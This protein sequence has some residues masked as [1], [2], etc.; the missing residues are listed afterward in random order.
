MSLK[1]WF[2]HNAISL[3]LPLRENQFFYRAFVLSYR[4]V[5]FSEIYC[6]FITLLFLRY[7][8]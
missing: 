1:K 6:S 5:Q 4:A 2:F 8:F 3:S 7:G